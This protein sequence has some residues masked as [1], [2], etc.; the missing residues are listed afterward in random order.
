[1]TTVLNSKR[2]M[3]RVASHSLGRI[4]ASLILICVVALGLRLGFM[5]DQQ[6]HLPKDR[7]SVVPFEYE[8]GNIAY[9]LATGKGFSSPLHVDTG[10]TAWLTPVYPAIVA[11][12][13]KIFGPYT[14]SAFEAA[15]LLNV[16]FSTLTCVPIYFAGA[17]IG[18]PG[19]GA[20]AAW[21]WAIFPAA[22]VIPFEWIWDT[23]LSALLGATILWATLVVAGSSRARDWCVYGALWGFT[24]MTNPSLG[25]LLPFFLVWMAWR[26]RKKSV[27]WLRNTA[28]A[29][30]VVF[31]ACLPWTIRNYEDFHA[32]VPLRST[33]GLQLWLGNNPFYIHEWGSWLHPIDNSDERAKF[34]AM[35][36]IPYMREKFSLGLHYVSAFPGRVAELTWQKFVAT[37]LGTAHPIHDFSAA[38]QFLE[39]AVDASNT[40]ISLGVLGGIVVLLVRRNPYAFPLISVPLAY[41]CLYYLTIALLRYRHPIDPVL[42]LL[43]AIAVG[44]ILPRRL[45]LPAQHPPSAALPQ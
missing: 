3:R 17:R 23:S 38:R 20:L 13:F 29:A 10:P 25:S 5:W 33:L 4:F 26:A 43:T 16:F 1:M 32:L 2:L 28:F 40:L 37:W 18:G 24:L 35:G 41:P 34:I 31:L 36:E 19:L 27:A 30:A 39:V 9:A 11:A 44:A 21:L 12:L 45:F 42:L 7:L 8:T 14:F 22:I 6:R 15:A